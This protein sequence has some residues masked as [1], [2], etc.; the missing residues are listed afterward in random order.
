MMPESFEDFSD[1]DFDAIMCFDDMAIQQAVQKDPST[2]TMIGY[3]TL[4]ASKPKL[5]EE[6]KAQFAGNHIAMEAYRNEVSQAGLRKRATKARIVMIAGFRRKRWKRMIAYYFV[7]QTCDAASMKA[8]IFVLLQLCF[9]VKIRV[10][11]IICDMGNR[12]VYRV[13]GVNSSGPVI[14]NYIPHP[15]DG[16]LKVYCSFDVIHVLK[17][18]KHMLVNNK[19]IILSAATAQLHGLQSH[20]VRL[21]HLKM[22]LE[23]QDKLTWKP[24]PYLNKK[25][26]TT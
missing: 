6:F 17:N 25:K 8:Q 3:C 20:V 7:G 22:H 15:C 9:N 1:E 4:P 24:A 14:Q 5:T 19:F 12:D 11:V 18:S 26:K 16:A 10:R 13:M 2:N 21:S 23:F